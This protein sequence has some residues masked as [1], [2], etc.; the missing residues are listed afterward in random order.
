MTGKSVGNC[1]VDLLQ[2]L[3]GG[4]PALY[5]ALAG[6]HVVDAAVSKMGLVPS[7]RIKTRSGGWSNNL[8]S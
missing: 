1:V 2:D 5:H 6:E 7:S 3:D 8:L 4:S